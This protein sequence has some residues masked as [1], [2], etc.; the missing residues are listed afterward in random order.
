MSHHYAE[1][2]ELAD[3]VLDW[4]AKQKAPL[5]IFA[6]LLVQRLAWR[7]VMAAMV[8]TEAAARAASP[9]LRDSG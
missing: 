1:G 9:K 6:R 3:R 8:L 4:V 5:V 7:R 2:E